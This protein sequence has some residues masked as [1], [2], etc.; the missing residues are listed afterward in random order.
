MRAFSNLNEEEIK[1]IF[2]KRPQNITSKTDKTYMQYALG[3][4]LY[5]P[6][7]RDDIFEIIYKNKY[8][9]MQSMVIC[10]EDAI[11]EKDVEK[12][13]TNV[14][15]V[16]KKITYCIETKKINPNNL[17]LI[18]L[19][20]RSIEQ[21]KK[22]LNKK[23]FFIPITGFVFPKF[24][25]TNGEEYLNI[26]DKFND[27]R[28]NILYGMPILE[29]KRVIYKESRI[30]ELLKIKSILDKYKKYILNVRI[31][32]TDY[33]GLYSLRRGIDN[34]I[35]DIGVV[36]DCIYDIINIFSRADNE[37][38]ISGPV[39]E[40]FNSND[41]NR[42]LKPMLRKTPF[43]ENEG[44]EGIIKRKHYLEKY[45]DGLIRE[46]ILDKANGLVGKTVIHPT[47]IKLVN[48]LYT[49]TQ[50]EYE[51]ALEILQIN[52]EGG[53][54]KSKYNNKMNESKPHF[55]WANKIMKRAYV[56]GVIKEE[57]T[58]LKLL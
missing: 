20:V 29:S 33:Q 17:P 18:F 28:T 10:L 30:D 19:R 11:S 26:L 38:V 8:N 34:S 2:Y 25:S 55:N 1:D 54:N 57:F 35:Y 5:M 4:T 58:Y 16:C 46:V 36:S 7:V 39:W 6:G 51:D 47:H 14:I 24:D 50:E 22:I 15:D 31:G 53:V 45:V 56:Y 49:V 12:A 23:G 40:Y 41:Q 48:A 9:S 3:A 27:N 52:D 37:Y 32:A 21:F 44:Q 42:V 43:V 13:E